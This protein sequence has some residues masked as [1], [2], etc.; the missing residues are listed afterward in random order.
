MNVTVPVV[1]PTD[2]ALFLASPFAAYTKLQ[3]GKCDEM[4][5]PVSPELNHLRKMGNKVEDTLL[6]EKLGVTD[7]NS[8]DFS[9]AVGSFK[10][11]QDKSNAALHCLQEIK[12][13][14]KKFLLQA[15]LACFVDGIL[16]FGKVDALMLDDST[17]TY[18]PIEIKSAYEA[19][20]THVL[21]L[22]A[23]VWMLASLQQGAANVNRIPIVAADTPKLARTVLSP[24]QLK[25]YLFLGDGTLEEIKAANYATF[26]DKVCR[27]YDKMATA[28]SCEDANF[29]PPEPLEL[30]NQQAEFVAAAQERMRATDSLELLPNATHKQRAALQKLGLTTLEGL[31]RTN[32]SETVAKLLGEKEFRM[33]KEHANLLDPENKQHIGTWLVKKPDEVFLG[34][35]VHCEDSTFF[36]N[37]RLFYL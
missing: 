8:I 13:K 32:F 21:Q 12:K 34:I 11:V 3:N 7:E 1:T 20:P 5:T 31:R 22:L 10:T 33:L 4:A 19:K 35:L 37:T 28:V 15:P 2:L 14:E 29:T 18:I 27:Q 36:C 30:E 23:Y 6:H 24:H 17:G 16:Y 25:A 26:F 9:K